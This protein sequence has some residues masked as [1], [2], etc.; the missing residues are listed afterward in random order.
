MGQVVGFTVMAIWPGDEA[1][2]GRS[3]RGW[4]ALGGWCVMEL[5]SGTGPMS[6]RLRDPDLP[7]SHLA[8]GPRPAPI[9]FGVG[10][11]ESF[12]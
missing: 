3:R 7:L 12:S 8:Q 6:N 4:E 1:G 10:S 2:Q 5:D 9:S 11:P